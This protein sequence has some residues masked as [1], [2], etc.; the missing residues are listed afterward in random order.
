MSGCGKLDNNGKVVTGSA[1]LCGTK[2]TYGVGKETKRT[3][4]HLCAECEA[5]NDRTQG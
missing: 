5:R 4:T 1:L 3:E 2:L